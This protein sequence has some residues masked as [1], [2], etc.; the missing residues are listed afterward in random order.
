MG[1]KITGFGLGALTVVTAGLVIAAFAQQAPATV[2]AEPRPTF[3]ASSTSEPEAPATIES[4]DLAATMARLD[5]TATP[6]ALTVLGDSTGNDGDEWVAS[7]ARTIATERNRP[8]TYN[9]WNATTGTYAAPITYGQGN[10]APVTI[11]NGSAAGMGPDYSLANLPALAANPSDLLIVNHGHN[12]ASPQQGASDEAA[13]VTATAA[14]WQTTPAVAV[15]LQN[16]R[17]TDAAAQDANLAAV[18]A[19]VTGSSYTVIDVTSAFR[20]Q[21]DLAALLQADGTHPNPAGQA[22][23]SQTVTATLGL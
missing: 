11:W 10:S 14:Q 23:W 5:D 19:V 6:W 9:A 2:S 12:F 20:A 21:P 3:T 7:L 18:S 15:T 13:L 17:L 4:A 8:V 16:P 22:V 1:N